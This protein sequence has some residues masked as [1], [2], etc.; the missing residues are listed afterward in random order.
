MGKISWQESFGAF[1]YGKSQIH[2]VVNYIETQEQH[3][4]MRNGKRQP[5]FTGRA[6]ILL[7]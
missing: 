5:A 7:E 2:G 4:K 1:S 3:K 6:A